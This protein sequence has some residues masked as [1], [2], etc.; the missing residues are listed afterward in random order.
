MIYVGWTPVYIK[1]YTLTDT[2]SYSVTTFNL[3]KTR[4]LERTLFNSMEG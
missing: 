2:G 3:I 1:M 4:C